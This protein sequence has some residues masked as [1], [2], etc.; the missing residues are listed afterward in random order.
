M[1]AVAL[2]ASLPATA[3]REQDKAR[4]E[5]L[6]WLDRSLA[7]QQDVETADVRCSLWVSEVNQPAVVSYSTGM[8]VLCRTVPA[9]T[10]CGFW[11][12][13]RLTDFDTGNESRIV[14]NGDDLFHAPGDSVMTILPAAEASSVPLFFDEWHERLVL[15]RESLVMPDSLFRQRYPNEGWDIGTLT[16]L[17][18]TVIDGRRCKQIRNIQ[19]DTRPQ[20]GVWFRN[21][22]LFALDA[23]T[24]LPVYHR[25]H[26][27]RTQRGAKTNDQVVVERVE[28]FRTGLSIP[29]S[30][31]WS[32][33]LPVK[34][35]I[36]LA[37]VTDT[38]RLR[39]DGGK[40]VLGRWP[41]TGYSDS[42][43]L[44]QVVVIDFSYKGC[45]YC[46][47]AL[48]VF[49]SLARAYGSDS[50]VQFL[51][52]DPVDSPKTI[53]EY[54]RAKGVAFPVLSVG[55]RF[56]ASFGVNAYPVFVILG[57]DGTQKFRL[58]GYPGSR[59]RLAGILADEL[60]RLLPR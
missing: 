32:P 12:S 11:F 20:Y 36:P 15:L 24:A 48:P 29:D 22:E 34:T 46:Q 5:L 17:P 37:T 18:D 39:W 21:T 56:A 40:D 31:F 2:L 9:D 23:A 57:P 8:N 55:E 35:E 10:V 60:K 59:E 47:L 33:G 49:D 7:A 45:G 6:Q 16:A 54:A 1:L 26:F 25:T 50:R 42:T 58:G 4:R 53:Q 41:Q 13:M 27:E 43:M 3:A 51:M 38:T 44:G 52:I 19:T 30:V 28:S 14:Y